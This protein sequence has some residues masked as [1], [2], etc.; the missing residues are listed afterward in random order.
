M[1]RV[2]H[3]SLARAA[4]G[5][6]PTLSATSKR[7]D[8]VFES[9]HPGTRIPRAT[10]NFSTGCAPRQ[11]TSIH[12]TAHHALR[13]NQMSIQPARNRTRPSFTAGALFSA[14]TV[15]VLLCASPAAAQPCGG[16]H[17]VSGRYASVRNPTV[18]IPTGV[19]VGQFVGDASTC[20]TYVSGTRVA[21]WL[22]TAARLADDVGGCI[23]KCGPSTQCKVGNDGLPV[24]LL[25]C[26]V[27]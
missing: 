11:L 17:A 14:S 4:R 23:F 18:C 26:G 19:T 16:T 1:R 10:G 15:L 5:S 27:E 12:Q 24:E 20:V 22:N 2:T 9:A 13:G 25:H 7:V 8:N 6:S 3:R 21:F